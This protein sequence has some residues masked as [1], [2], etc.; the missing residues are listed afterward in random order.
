MGRREPF[1]AEVHDQ[2]VRI[3]NKYSSRQARTRDYGCGEDLY[4]AEIHAIHAIGK[5]PDVHMAKLARILGV[6]RGAI[7]QTVGRLVKKG[8]AE[9]FMDEDDAKKVYVELTAKGN[10]AFEG[11]EEFHAEFR[12]YVAE[13][14]A[15][16]SSKEVDLLRRFLDRMESFLDATDATTPPKRREKRQ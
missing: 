9:K 1:F 10:I 7:Q 13:P 14:L 5:H 11:H 6:T 4:P 15:R 3:A 2:F 12:S 8:L 16:L